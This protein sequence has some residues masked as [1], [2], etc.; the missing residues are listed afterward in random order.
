[1]EERADATNVNNWHWTERDATG[2]STEHLKE[3]L[4]EIRVEGPEGVC[5]ITDVPKL[6]GEASVNNRKGKLIFFYEWVLRASWMGT[7]IT[8]IKYKGNV[9]VPNLSDENDMDDLDISVTMCKD[10]P[11]TPLINLMKR[12]GVKRVRS[13]LGLYVKHL[14]SE[15]TQGMILPTDKQQPNNVNKPTTSKTPTKTQASS[16]PSPAIPASSSAAAP[17]AGVRIPTCSFS[18]HET[19]LTS[20]DEIY[21]TFLKQEFVQVFTR[22]DAVVDGCRGGKFQ[23]MNG[24]V[25]GEFTELVP[26]EKIVMR[27]RFKSWPS[28]H[29]ATISLAFRDKGDETELNLEAKGVPSD[30]EER[31]KEGWRR[32]YFEAIKQSFGYGARLY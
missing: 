14:R 7:T 18:L 20:P 28:D 13:A 10:E 22:S 4:L 23:M 8:G 6:D 1:V 31:T 25:H 2:W 21:V 29:Y 16:A 17:A 32:F 30:E 11:P 26:N 5:N 27:W 15:Y 3:L 19:F 12:E 24:N 9:D